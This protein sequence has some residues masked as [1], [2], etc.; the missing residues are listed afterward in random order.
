[1]NSPRV[2]V[3]VMIPW[4]EE[5][6]RLRSLEYVQ[7]WYRH[8]LGVEPI[9]CDTD[10]VEFNR[11]GARNECVRQATE[12]VIIINDADTIPELSPLLS[13]VAQIQIDSLAQLP[14]TLWRSLDEIASE[15]VMSGTAPSE[16]PGLELDGSVGGV[17]VTTRDIWTRHGGQDER[18]VAWG[19]EDA[20]WCMAHDTLV[21][22]M[23]RH[24]GYIY[25][26]R[27]TPSVR[28]ET[29][30]NIGLELV[31]RYHQANGNPDAM[32]ELVFTER[33][34]QIP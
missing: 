17:M 12:Q 20:A 10:H 5:P 9:L 28:E 15:A 19:Y 3:S 2:P 1:M 7:N 24:S 4:R 32:R 25:S 6:S 18:F 16:R 13:A 23:R 26:L 27:H 8:N 21:G 33:G 31:Y 11:A 22:A 30:Q 34:L 29:T 14:Y